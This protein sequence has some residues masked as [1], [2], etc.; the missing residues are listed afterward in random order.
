MVKKM[1]NV[2]K[3]SKEQMY[4]HWTFYLSLPKLLEDNVALRDK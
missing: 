2:P 3:F 1:K 4:T